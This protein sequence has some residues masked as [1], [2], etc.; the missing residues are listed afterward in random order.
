[1]LFCESFFHVSFSY[2]LCSASRCQLLSQ[3]ISISKSSTTFCSI[4]NFS[5]LSFAAFFMSLR[6]AFFCCSH[7]FLKYSSTFSFPQNL[8]SKFFSLVLYSSLMIVFGIT[9][10]K[11]F[12]LTSLIYSSTFLTNSVSVFCCQ[13]FSSIYFF[14]SSIFLTLLSSPNSFLIV[15]SLISGRTIFLISLITKRM[16]FTSFT[17]S[18]LYFTVGGSLESS[19][20][21]SN[22]SFFFF[23]IKVFLK[24]SNSSNSGSHT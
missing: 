10:S 4:K 5:K 9:I 6:K 13:M 3:F 23:Q 14:N 17:S 20:F 12:S 15:S 18:L 11:L 7:N 24:K 22:V 1:M 16:F 19:Y 2:I 21:T 8:F